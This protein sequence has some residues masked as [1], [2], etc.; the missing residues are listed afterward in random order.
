MI[1]RKLRI[2]LVFLIFAIASTVHAQGNTKQADSPK[3]IEYTVIGNSA[4]MRSGPGT[5]FAVAGKV[6]KGESLLIYD[7]PAQGGWLRVYRKGQDDAYIADFLVERAPLRFYPA[8][9]SPLLEASGQGKKVTEVFDIPKGAYRID[10]IVEDNSFILGSTVVD[11]N[12]SDEY[13]FNEL[14]FNAKRLVISGLFISQGCSVIFQTE[15]VNGKWQFA[16]RDIIVDADF[17]KE[18]ALKIDNSTKISGLGRALTMAT[19]LPEGV[20]TIG[21]T[22]KD[23]ALIVQAQVLTGDCESG[24]VFNEVDFNSKSLELSSAYKSPSGG[25]IIYWETSN[26]EGAWELS[27]NK[28]R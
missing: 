26:I 25:C 27:F 13:I 17:L 19:I 9:Q 2:A 16:L 20:W 28:I 7:E 5:T 3:L 12:C 21:A 15:N 14:N 23:N 10:A 4:N 24:T 1:H 8:S 22:A 11:G 6:A 18:N